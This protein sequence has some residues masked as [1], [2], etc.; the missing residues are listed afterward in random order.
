MFIVLLCC[1]CIES[2]FI[3]D[4]SKCDY[5]QDGNYLARALSVCQTESN[6]ATCRLHLGRGSILNV[7]DNLKVS[8]YTWNS[9]LLVSV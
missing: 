3:S 1:D 5:C 2:I 8:L 7:V 4:I 6:N 9:C